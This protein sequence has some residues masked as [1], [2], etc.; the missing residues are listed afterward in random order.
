MKERINLLNPSAAS[1]TQGSPEGPG[2][3]LVTICILLVIITVGAYATMLGLEWQAQN[4][5]VAAQKGITA[6]EI[7]EKQRELEA[8][9]LADKDRIVAEI[10]RLNSA[11]PVFSNYLDELKALTPA[12]VVLNS[13]TVMDQPFAASIKGISPTT[14]QIAQLGRNLQESIYFKNSIISSGQKRVK[15]S[16]FE[17]LITVTPEKKGGLSR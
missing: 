17:F 14:L 8:N 2:R 5:I 10:E 4:R 6:Q 1:K 13:V 3:K 11:K 16:Y 7:V 15:E 9:L 12:N